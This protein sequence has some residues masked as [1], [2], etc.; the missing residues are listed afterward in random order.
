MHHITTCHKLQHVLYGKM[1]QKQTNV[2]EQRVLKQSN[3]CI[4]L[5]FLHK[6]FLHNICAI[7][8]YDKPLMAM[9][10]KLLW[11]TILNSAIHHSIP[12]SAP[13]ERQQLLQSFQLS[14]LCGS[15]HYQTFWQFTNS[16]LCKIKTVQTL[17]SKDPKYFTPGI[18]LFSNWLQHTWVAPLSKY[19]LWKSV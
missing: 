17:L 1:S 16:A 10:T 3:M 19:W 4:N 15:L 14:L 18:C 5:Q 8:S 12:A 9:L 11:P 13:T 6:R 2:G 7:W